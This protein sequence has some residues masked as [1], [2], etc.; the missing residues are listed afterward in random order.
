MRRRTASVS[1]PESEDRPGTLASN[2]SLP[3]ELTT[4]SSRER[5][6]GRRTTSGNR[7]STHDPFQVNNHGILNA[8]GLRSCYFPLVF[9]G[10]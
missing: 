10:V 2:W 3:H 5:E 4:S 8:D 9:V 6:R 7:L 1:K